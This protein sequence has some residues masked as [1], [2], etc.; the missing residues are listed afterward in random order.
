MKLVSALGTK[1][2]A[3]AGA[4]R[5]VALAA[6]A[7]CLDH[8]PSYLLPFNAFRNLLDLLTL[9]TAAIDLPVWRQ[10]SARIQP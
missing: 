9:L 4:L 1:L 6:L 8:K 7:S 3:Q 5:V 2:G 10:Y